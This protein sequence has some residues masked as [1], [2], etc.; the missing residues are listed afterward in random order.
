MRRV[1]TRA[2]AVMQFFT[3]EKP[4]FI[5]FSCLIMLTFDNRIH[6]VFFFVDVWRK[7]RTI[8]SLF[9]YRWR[10]FLW[11]RSFTGWKIQQVC[12]TNW[13]RTRTRTRKRSKSYRS[14]TG[15]CGYVAL[16]VVVKSAGLFLFSADTSQE[17]RVWCN[18][19]VKRWACARG[20][21]VSMASRQFP[22]Q[23][24]FFAENLR[25]NRCLAEYAKDML[26]KRS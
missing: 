18:T 20:S 15:T 16:G 9:F 5:V 14:S 3:I 10:F 23:I 7:F 6:L 25:N 12:E 17:N 11:W 19:A 26:G 24:P 13:C 22:A 1:Q 21:R 2:W 4:Y 8:L